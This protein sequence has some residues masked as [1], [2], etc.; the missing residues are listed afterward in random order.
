[1]P[2]AFGH[3]RSEK[4]TT[5]SRCAPADAL[6]PQKKRKPAKAS[7]YGPVARHG[8]S[9]SAKNRW[10]NRI[11]SKVTRWFNKVFVC[12]LYTSPSPRDRSLS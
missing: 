7:P 6:N 10:E 12:L 11:L 5:T 2:P 4:T 1:M 3:R 9:T 8:H